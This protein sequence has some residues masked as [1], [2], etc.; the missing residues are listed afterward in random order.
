M[1]YLKRGNDSTVIW[2]L[3]LFVL[4]QEHWTISLLYNSCKELPLFLLFHY[5]NGIVF[6][7]IAKTNLFSWIEQVIVTA[8]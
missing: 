3:Y 2:E 4:Y 5:K 6:V 8:H 7:K 1:V